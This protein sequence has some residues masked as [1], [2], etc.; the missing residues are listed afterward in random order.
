MQIFQGGGIAIV[1]GRYL[2]Y[3]VYVDPAS[4]SGCV[5]VDIVFTD[6]TTLR[7]N[8]GTTYLYNDAQNIPPHPLHDIGG[9]AKGTWYHRKFLLDNF[10]GKTIS[11]VTVVLEGNAQGTYTAY[12][13][14]I[15]ET[16]GSGTTINTF[17]NGTLNVNPP[18]RMQNSGY[19]NISCTLVNTYDCITQVSQRVSPSYQI[20]NA[21][22]IKNSFLSSVTTQPTNTNILIEYSLDGGNSYITCKNNAALPSLLAGLSV[23][24]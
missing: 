13:K 21:N 17:F 6:G 20:G 15:L 8:T 16:N 24:G 7:D 22:I 2:E 3:D 1:S 11:Y 23:G 14:N 19:S 4:P 18:K 10:S 9:F 5:G 12:F